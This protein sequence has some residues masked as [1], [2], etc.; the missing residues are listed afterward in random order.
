MTLHPGVE[1]CREVTKEEHLT[2][3]SL[4]CRPKMNKGVYHP[5]AHLVVKVNDCEH[6]LCYLEKGIS[7]QQGLDF[8]FQEGDNLAL[9]V[10]GTGK[11]S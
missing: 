11:C 7:H 3:A 9:S 8:I 5:L 1:Y 10:E 2:L 6:V 4:D